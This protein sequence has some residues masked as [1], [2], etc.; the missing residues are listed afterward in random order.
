[1]S[2]RESET[3]EVRKKEME[4]VGSGRGEGSEM[5]DQRGVVKE[6]RRRGKERMKEER[7]ERRTERSMSDTETIWCLRA[8]TIP[9]DCLI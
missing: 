1:M 7:R 9:A 5:R 3:E 8:S 4:T 2:D 6:G